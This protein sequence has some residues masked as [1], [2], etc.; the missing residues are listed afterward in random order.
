M[1]AIQLQ[2]PTG[3]WHATPWGRQVNEGAVEW[4]PSNWRLL[5]ALLA[6][7]HHKF[8]DVTQEQIQP[9]LEALAVPP[10][11]HLPPASQ[12]HTRHYMPIA[13]DNRTK[14]FDTFVAVGPESP[15]IVCWHDACLDDS[16]R[17]LL[18]RLLAAM[19]YFGRAESWVDARLLDDWEGEPNAYPLN[20]LGVQDR[21]ELVRLLCPAAQ[22]EYADWRERTLGD[23]LTRKLE[24]KKTKARQKGKADDKIKLSAK[25]TQA[26]EGTLPPTIFEALH[27]ETD[28]IRGAGWNRPPGSQW[29]DYV[30][31]QQSFAPQ[32]SATRRQRSMHDK[33]TLAR[34]AIASSVRPQLLD[35]L[36]IG[37]RIRSACMSKSQKLRQKKLNDPEAHA[38]LV[39]SGKSADNAS[40]AGHQHAHFLVE[41][42]QQDRRINHVSVY[43]PMGFSRDDELALARVR[44]VW[45]DDDHKI[46]LVLLGIGKPVDFG[47]LDEKKGQSPISACAQIWVSRTP[48]VP[49]DHLRIR[50]KEKRS[51]ELL[52]S[53][54]D[55]E[56]DRIVRKEMTRRDWLSQYAASVQISR[57]PHTH[58]GGT[59][60]N[61]LKFRRDRKKGSGR[62]SSSHGYG[63]QLTF[64]EPVEG[65]IALGYG[66]HFGLGLFV[67]IEVSP[68][69]GCSNGTVAD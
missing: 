44:Q 14:I 6:V 42:A 37:E 5:R 68:Q 45:G 15:V 8:S 29:I 55:R 16:Q 2:F 69:A 18:Q 26:L 51:P 33:P 40:V 22:G 38:A 24:E 3:K 46:Q 43:A 34:Y 53:A 27:A 47:G 20:E 39:F 28:D 10:A 13:N 54:V 57:V 66:A 7:W 9:L 23:L 52:A 17:S 56:L 31:S 4:P 25:E 30:R 19:F 65:P 1:I 41:A 49:T 36:F 48:F 60:T 63:F 50:D 35:A 59:R 32:V 62:K 58:V 67:P 11:Y 12:G 64:P 61:W 21:Q